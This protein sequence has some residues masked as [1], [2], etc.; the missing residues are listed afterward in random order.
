MKFVKPS[1]LQ[2]FAKHE[3]LLT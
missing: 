2:N 1:K 3:I